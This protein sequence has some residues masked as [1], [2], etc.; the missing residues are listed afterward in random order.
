MPETPNSTRPVRSE[1]RSTKFGTIAGPQHSRD[2]RPSIQHDLADP[3]ERSNLE[4]LFGPAR[5]LWALAALVFVFAALTFVYERFFFQEYRYKL[6]LTI[7][8][9]EGEK[10]ASSVVGLSVRNFYIESYLRGRKQTDSITVLRGTAP[11]V[12]LGRYGWVVAALRVTSPGPLTG[13]PS[14]MESI[15]QP[16]GLSDWYYANFGVKVVTLD[17]VSR[18]NRLPQFIWL[19]ASYEALNLATH[20]APGDFGRTIG[21]GVVFKSFSFTSTPAEVA[22]KVAEPPDWLMKLRNGTRPSPPPKYPV[23]IIGLWR[24][25]T[26]GLSNLPSQ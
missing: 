20:V 4:K 14:G 13:F 18:E 15:L 5:R 11:I 22:F 8:T 10:S 6:T 19:P 16:R 1:R 12:D 25:E 24:L 9:P 7:D 3:T 17:N 21:N 23:S 26:E 2:G